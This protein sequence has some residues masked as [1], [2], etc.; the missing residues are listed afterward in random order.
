MPGLAALLYRLVSAGMYTEQ[1]ALWSMITRRRLLL[2][3]KKYS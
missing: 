1:A 2:T 3:V